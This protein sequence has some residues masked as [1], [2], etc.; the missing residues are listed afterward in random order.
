MTTV[1]ERAAR[2]SDTPADPAPP[3]GPAPGWTVWGPGVAVA[4]ALVLPQLGRRSLWLDESFTLGAINQYGSTF[5]HTGGTMSLYYALLAPWAAVS[6]D[7]AWLRAP[8]LVCGLLALVALARFASVAYGARIARFACL[9][10]ASSMLFVVYAAETR[11]YALVL[12]LATWTWVAL[13]RLVR[14]EGGARSQNR[15]AVGFAVAWAVL[16]WAHG[17][18]TLQ[19]GAQVAV[20]LVARPPRSLWRRV[21]PALVLGLG[22]TVLG[23]LLGGGQS[24]AWVPPISGTALL[25]QVRWL[26]SLQTLGSVVLLGFVVVGTVSTLGDVRTAATPSARFRA[27]TP[28]MWGVLPVL[29]LVVLSLHQPVLVPRYSLTCVPGVALLL[30]LGAQAAWRRLVSTGLTP[31]LAR[32][33]PMVLIFLVLASGQATVASWAGDDWRGAADAIAA[34]ARPGDVVAFPEPRDRVPFEVAW[35]GDSRPSFLEPVAP[36]RPF[37]PVRYFDGVVDGRAPVVDLP[38]GRRAFVVYQPASRY[39]RADKDR[40][41]GAARSRYRTTWTWTGAGGVQVWLLA[42]R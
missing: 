14:G 18:S 23:T 20:L 12:A 2:T 16:P 38:P 41:L 31:R 32:A 42:P 33:T 1:V 34:R 10:A 26:T 5:A 15:W 36:G 21:T 40:L 7:P 3:G 27:A 19:L 24:T 22:G 29:A 37:G 28:A 4:L 6:H 9:A 39:S 30:V 8:S 11:S 25:G 13:D 35:T 17:L